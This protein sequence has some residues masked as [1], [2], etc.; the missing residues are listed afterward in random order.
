MISEMCFT[1]FIY[2]YDVRTHAL[3]Y[4]NAGVYIYF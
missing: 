3:G 2:Y 4:V 1:G